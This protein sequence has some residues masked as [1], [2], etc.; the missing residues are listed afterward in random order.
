MTLCDF[1]GYFSLTPT[2][3]VSALLNANM[4]LNE[5]ECCVEESKF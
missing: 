1:E 4:W 5:A 3:C 2:T